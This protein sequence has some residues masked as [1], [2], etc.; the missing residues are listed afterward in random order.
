MHSLANYQFSVEETEDGFIV[1]ITGDK[2]ALKPKLEA[3]EAFINFR[4]K[5]Q[6]AGFGGHHHGQGHCGG[7]LGLMRK[8][9]KAM[10]KKISDP[11]TCCSE[12][13]K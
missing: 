4:Q 5:A 6:A 11:E 12:Q 8:H 9:F 10:H 13:K 3:F 1:N 7:M 2:E